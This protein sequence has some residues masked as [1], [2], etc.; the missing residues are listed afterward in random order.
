M[1]NYRKGIKTRERLLKKIRETLNE[2]GM[3]L[4][5]DQLSQKLGVSKGRIT[6]YFPTK[7]QIFVALSEEYDQVFQG[8]VHEYEWDGDYSLFKV[9]ELFGK[10]MDHQYRYRCVIYYTVI[11]PPSELGF[12]TQLQK[13]YEENGKEVKTLVELLVS[14]GLLN[15]EIL[16]AENYEIFLF[17]HLCLF[18]NWVM[19]IRTYQ[20]EMDYEREKQIYLNSLLMGYYPYFTPLGLTQF[21]ELKTRGPAISTIKRT[22]GSNWTENC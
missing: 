12:S 6:N 1:G 5:F 7:E 8:I 16:E 21:R 17:Q 2:D 22:R 20:R 10:I 14:R 9:A 4:T 19:T 3:L 18:T 15:A 11:A 13:S